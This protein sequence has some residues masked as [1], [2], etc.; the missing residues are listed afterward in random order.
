ME[1]CGDNSEINKN[2][3]NLDYFFQKCSWCVKNNTVNCFR[4]CQYIEKIMELSTDSIVS[5]F[6]T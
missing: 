2:I 5:D 4:L 1:E 3:F 6:N